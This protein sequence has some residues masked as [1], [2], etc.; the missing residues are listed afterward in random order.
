MGR[1]D[2]R[3]AIVTGA[4]RGIGFAIASAMLREGAAVAITGRKQ[5][6]V[7]AAAHELRG[8]NP[9]AVVLPVASHAGDPAAA[10]ALAAQVEA[11][12][13]V[14]D[15]LVNNAATNPYFG[16]LLDVDAALWR[17]TFEVNLD[18]PF[19]LTR[20]VCARL[21]ATG[22]TGSVVF[23]SSVF[24]LGA[25]PLQGVYGLT[26]AATIAL[27]KT[28]AAEL[29]GAGIRVNAIAPG[30]VDT[31]FAAMLVQDPTLSARFT[32]RAALRR[33]GKPE[34]IAGAVVY[35]SSDEASFTTGQVLVVDGG[36]A[37][38]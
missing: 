26:K 37:A 13:G 6:G 25:A 28:L 36:Y 22:N 29:G 14:V 38:G 11:E 23:V 2:G 3:V 12:L 32:D 27:T 5:A 16:P 9:G 10:R 8:A 34:E 20:A 30:L 17:K 31:R 24:G 33:I 7:D 18:G 1:L 21:V 15:V 35:L 19:E 4:T